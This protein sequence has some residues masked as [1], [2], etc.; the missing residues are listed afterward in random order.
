MGSAYTLREY[1]E[2]CR[3]T[4][5]SLP[6]GSRTVCVLAT[7]LGKTVMASSF[8]FHGRVL[9]LSHRDELVRQPEKYFT[10][11]GMTFGIEKAGEHENGEDVVS[12]SIQ[13]ICRE[14]RL[15]K[16]APDEF[17]VIICD[18]VQHAAAPTYRKV[19]SY[20]KPR[21]LIGLTATPKR[22]DNVRLTDSFDSI[23]FTRD[24]KW[25]IQN[26]YLSNIRCLLVE[27]RYDMGKVKKTMGEFTA[28]GL[29]D[30]MSVSDDDMV[31]TKAY[32][33]H[34][35]PEGRQT[36][37]YCPTIKVCN[38]VAATLRKSL[39]EGLEGTVQVLSD[40]NTPE[41]RHDIL[42][43]YREGK[44]KC[45]INCMILTEG[46]DLPETSA[47]IV[48]RPSANP[49]LYTQI[50]GRGTRLAEGKE[51]C[52]VIDVIGQNGR[53]KHICTAPTLFGVEP[54][55]LPAS[56]RKKF[57]EGDLLEICEG[58]AEERAG[59]AASM[60]IKK[61]IVDFFTQERIAMVEKAA[62]NGYKAIAGA[63]ARKLEEEAPDEYGF[64]D[65]LVFKGALDNHLYSVNATFK[66][67]IFFSKP[68]MLGNTDLEVVIPDCGILHKNGLNF[69]KEGI[70][71]EEA[72]S[73][74][75]LLLN[76]G[77]DT[78]YR[79]KWSKS[80]MKR[81]AGFP[82]TEKQ[83]V[84]IDIDYKGIPGLNSNLVDINRIEASSLIELMNEISGMRSEKK[85]IE[86]EQAFSNKKRSGKI[87]EKWEAKK[88]KEQED[89]ELEHKAKIRRGEKDY[90]EAMALL[91]AKEEASKK[92][93][94]SLQSVCGKPQQFFVSIDY[95]YF[96]DC[97]DPSDKQISFINSLTSKVCAGN[98]GFDCDTDPEALGLDMW[99]TGLLI[100]YLLKVQ[101]LPSYDM[102]YTEYALKS[103][104]DEIKKITTRNGPG[105]VICHYTIRQLGD[106][107]A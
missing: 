59:I 2:E 95:D 30:E 66:G 40:R 54:D 87:L 44:I 83:L 19:L 104:I 60:E 14:D 38:M 89:L 15:H 81:L 102:Y 62:K 27:A 86:A 69:I 31:V 55:M 32:L 33:E 10:A 24:L 58:I 21:K 64:G 51:Y 4:V 18:E 68:D 26:G 96:R 3:D 5:N 71:M 47:I 103:Y 50:V 43:G 105:R 78:Y 7:G 91:R 80:E 36:L 84:K 6:D 42:D 16:F 35:L 94:A 85:R 88:R 11:R 49:S 65:I 53:G 72:I 74:T 92:R 41:E 61:T 20:F 13:S 97:P 93:E 39:P 28:S 57:E 77:I 9:W 45:I 101:K 52:L 73:F 46:T 75:K 34:C 99:H 17:D 29:E 79:Q 67:K 48:N 98:A 100:N 76:Y 107:A 37:V 12:A 22:G 25:G 106:N 70:P 56:A 23:C 1:Q 90:P 63:Y 82:A 8:D